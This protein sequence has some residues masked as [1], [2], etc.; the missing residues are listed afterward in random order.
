MPY[1]AV[2]VVYAVG[3]TF[4]WEMVSELVFVDRRPL[5]PNTMQFGSVVVIEGIA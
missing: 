2:P 5:N 1:P 4:G 3:G